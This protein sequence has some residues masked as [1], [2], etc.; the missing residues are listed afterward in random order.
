MSAQRSLGVR[1]TVLRG[2]SV[3]RALCVVNELSV[4]ADKKVVQRRRHGGRATRGAR[5]EPHRQSRA[6]V[7]SSF[8]FFWR[9]TEIYLVLFQE[10]KEREEERRLQK[11]NK[12]EQP[13]KKEQQSKP[14][15]PKRGKLLCFHPRLRV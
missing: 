2:F 1:F 14:P 13:S 8:D 3:A 5:E 7:N 6:I 11:E 15:A 10:E 12:R 4:V 9:L